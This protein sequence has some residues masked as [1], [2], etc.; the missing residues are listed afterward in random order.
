[1]KIIPSHST[2]NIDG[3]L[4]TKSAGINAG[5]E[6]LATVSEIGEREGV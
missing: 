6:I 1:V 5:E 3:A 4:I 2:I